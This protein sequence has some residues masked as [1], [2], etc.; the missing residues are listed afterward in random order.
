MLVGRRDSAAMP[1]GQHQGCR[2]VRGG[3]F[4][5]RVPG[6]QG[7]DGL[8]MVLLGGHH[9][10]GPTLRG[11]RFGICAVREQIAQAIAQVAELGRV[12]QA[13]NPV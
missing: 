10:G 6:Y 7:L 2:T 5:V 4:A 3:R 9:E 11:S 13:I 12:P 1:G 8:G